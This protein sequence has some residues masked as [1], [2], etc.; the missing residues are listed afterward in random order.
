ML[1]TVPFDPAAALRRRA[2]EPS[3]RR[4]PSLWDTFPAKKAGFLDSLAQFNT[5][6]SRAVSVT[7]GSSALDKFFAERQPQALY[8]YVW[9]RNALNPVPDA[10]GMHQWLHEVL[11]SYE[12]ADMP[13]N[14][15]IRFANGELLDVNMRDLQ[16]G[17]TSRY[18]RGNLDLVRKHCAYV[19]IGPAQRRAGESEID[20]YPDTDTDTD[21]DAEPM[22][23]PTP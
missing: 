11:V 5:G 17:V 9:V 13:K 21:V 8:P 23:G 18:G 2:S 1:A 16:F 6:V 22:A 3:W 10:N 20:A 15:P 12:A 7:V 14:A 19:H 4:F